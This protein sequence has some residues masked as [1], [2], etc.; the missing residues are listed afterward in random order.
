[1]NK[2]VNSKIQGIGLLELMM[3]LGLIG[4]LLMSAVRYFA[5]VNRANR[6]NQ[7]IEMVN[8]I[9]AAG[10]RYKTVKDV[11]DQPTGGLLAA[12]VA[13]GFLPDSYKAAVVMNP[14]GGVVVVGPD[15]SDTSKLIIA[16]S[17]ITTASECRNFVNKIKGTSCTTDKASSDECTDNDTVVVHCG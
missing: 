5:L 17:G 13:R 4:I 7:A 14:W 12:F 10:E 16:L 1:M 11:Y 6:V 3:V 2:I 15:T 8:V 9:Y